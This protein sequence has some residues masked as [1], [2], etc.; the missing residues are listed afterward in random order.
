VSAQQPGEGKA[1]ILEL[2]GSTHD[3]CSIGRWV[4]EI[5]VFRQCHSAARENLHSVAKE[6]HMFE[7]S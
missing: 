1:K 5:R 2:K 6:K 3:E 4:A 7:F